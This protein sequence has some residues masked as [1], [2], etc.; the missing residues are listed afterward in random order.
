[1]AN[2]ELQL[3]PMAGKKFEFKHGGSIVCFN[4]KIHHI[5]SRF[6]SSKLIVLTTIGNK[7]I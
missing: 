3:F 5:F 4:V 2:K 1:M 7:Q 6:W